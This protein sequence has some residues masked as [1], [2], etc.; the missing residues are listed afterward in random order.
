MEDHIRPAAKRA[1]I[2]KRPGWHDSTSLLTIASFIRDRESHEVFKALLG[3]AEVRADKL[4]YK[5][6]WAAWQVTVTSRWREC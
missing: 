3:N 2:T 5:T 6:C 1:K 4:A